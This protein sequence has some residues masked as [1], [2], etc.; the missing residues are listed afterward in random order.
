[1]ENRKLVQGRVV[2]EAS[3]PQLGFLDGEV[4]GLNLG[5]FLVV[6]LHFFDDRLQ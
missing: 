5:Q 6:L 3:V 1:M 4:G 2:V